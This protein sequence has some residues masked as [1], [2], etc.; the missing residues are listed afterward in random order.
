MFD[1][2]KPKTKTAIPTFAPLG[3]DIHCHLLP[4]VDDGSKSNEESMACMKVMRDAGFEGIICT[5]HYQ[6]PRFPNEEPDILRRY[7]NLK[8]DLA[9]LNA[10]G[11]PQLR[12]VAGE[13][14]VDSGFAGRIQQ[15]QFLLVGG[16]YL[17]TEFSLHQQVIGLDQ[18]MFDL[19][20]KNYEVILAHPERYPYYSG[21]SS[22]LQHLKDMGVYFQVNILSL[23]GFYGEGPKHKAFEMIEKGWVEFLGT[24][25]HNTLYAQALIDASHDR[26]VIKL[27]EKHKFL[28]SQVENKDAIKTNKI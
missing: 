18:V 28:N 17:L 24:D 25:M 23:I 9:S 27:M 15:N 4:G 13:Y 22:K 1:F 20:M 21:A 8:L 10:Q 2:L 26:K 7:D 3:I 12:G 6:Y 5:P 16:N 14:R 11:I 19:Q